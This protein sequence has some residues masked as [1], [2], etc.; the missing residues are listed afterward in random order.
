M[1]NLE[2]IRASHAL[3][4]WN[5]RIGNGDVDGENGGDVVRG[6]GSL[7]I[8]NGLLA[9]LAYAREKEKGYRTLMEETGRFLCSSGDDGRNIWADDTSNLTSF[10]E[11]LTKADSR[12]LQ[13]ATAETL[14]YLGYL[15]RF[16]T[17]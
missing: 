4:F 15:K 7:I 14:A 6:L 1:K 13:R 10:I 12:V 3:E 11:K 8:N 9:T 2:Q 16:R 17:Q 5:K